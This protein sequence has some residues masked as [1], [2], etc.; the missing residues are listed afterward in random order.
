MGRLSIDDCLSLKK[1]NKNIHNLVMMGCLI[2]YTFN[3]EILT[4]LSNNFNSTF[5]LRNIL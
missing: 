2:K 4:D 1:L 5:H 3:L